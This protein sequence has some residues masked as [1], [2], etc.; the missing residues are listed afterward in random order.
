MPKDETF[1]TH[2]HVLADGR[3]LAFTDTGPP[4]ARDVLVCLPGVLETRQTFVPV[5]DA[6]PAGLRCLSLDYCGRGDSDPLP[7]DH[8]YSMARYCDDLL[9]FLGRHLPANTRLHVLGTSMGGILAFYLVSSRAFPVQTLLL[10]DIGL[11][12]H[13]LS[14]LSMYQDMKQGAGTLEPSVL[15]ARLKVT[16]GRWLRCSCRSTLICLTARAFAA[17]I[18]C[19]CWKA[20]AVRCVWFVGSHPRFARPCKCMNGAN[21]TFHSKCWKSPAWPI[22]CRLTRRSASFC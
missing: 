6:R 12:L 15:A 19:T 11:S 14:L 3:R 5:L 4:H 13:W 1:P 17:C 21:S 22:R 7:G 9:H 18:S 20:M 8:G 16:R 10:N 2:K